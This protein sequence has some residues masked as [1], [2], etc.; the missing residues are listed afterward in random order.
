MVQQALI[1]LKQGLNP[2]PKTKMHIN[3]NKYPRF[4]S[5][6][7]KVFKVGGNIS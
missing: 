2:E 3:V 5:N 4:R 7:F 1:P 6:S